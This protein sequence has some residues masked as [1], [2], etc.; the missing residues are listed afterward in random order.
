MGRCTCY[1]P[2]EGA[3]ERYVTDYWTTKRSE[4]FVMEILIDI[5]KK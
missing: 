4:D 5:D 2:G 3:I 1:R